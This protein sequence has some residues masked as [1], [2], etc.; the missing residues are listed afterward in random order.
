[1]PSA[2]QGA[3]RHAIDPSDELAMVCSH[4]HV[5][6]SGHIERGLLAGT[7]PGTKSYA[8]KLETSSPWHPE[9]KLWSHGESMDV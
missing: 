9:Y 7:R 6:E 8:H 4:E 2:W 1:M 3:V 5:D